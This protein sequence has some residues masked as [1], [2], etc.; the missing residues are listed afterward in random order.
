MPGVQSLAEQRYYAHPR[1]AFWLITGALFGFD[2]AAPYPDRVTALTAAGVAVWD[3]LK[4]CRRPGSLD[5]SV[6]PKSMVPNDFESFFATH[7]TIDEVYFN[8]AA[9]Q[10]NY[11]RLVTVDRPVNH[12]LLPS[13]S[14]ALT[15]PFATKLAAWQ[16]IT[17]DSGRR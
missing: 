13:T 9:A 8:G 2:A 17:N 15:V 5:A 12:T 11:R 10:K 6:D 1:N 7:P 3:V 4:F 16:G 14:P